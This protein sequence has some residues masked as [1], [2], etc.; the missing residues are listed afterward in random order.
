MSTKKTKLKHCEYLVPKVISNDILYPY[1]CSKMFGREETTKGKTYLLEAFHYFEKQDEQDFNVIDVQI[2][3]EETGRIVV[4]SSITGTKSE[5]S[6]I[7]SLINYA[8]GETI[9]RI[10]A[11][12][13][14]A[15]IEKSNAKRQ[16]KT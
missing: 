8:T 9:S 7:E 16:S 10:I 13:L 15:I 12:G 3:E 14:D 5:A 2:V 4:K 1:N 11:K 6:E